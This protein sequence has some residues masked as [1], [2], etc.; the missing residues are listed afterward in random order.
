MSL[1]EV[2]ALLA[3]GR[4]FLLI[5][6]KEPDGDA[7]G[8]LLALGHS[9]RA[10]GKDVVLFTEEP[11]FPPFHLLRGARRIVHRLPG[12]MEFDAFVALDCAQ[13]ERLGGPGDV[14]GKCRALVNI[15]HHETNGL[16][17]D[18]H[19]VDPGCSSTGELVYRV[20]RA[21]GLP[22]GRDVAE[23]VF[24]AMQTDTG[25]F[26]Y[27]NTSP[28]CLRIAADLLDLGVSPWKV[29]RKILEGYGARRLELLRL[30]LGTLEFHARGRIGMMMLFSSMLRKT[31]ARRTDSE[32]FVDFP[33]AVKGVRIAVLIREMEEGAWKFSLRA[34]DETNVAR[35]AVRFHGGGHARAAGFEAQ[36]RLP[37]LRDRFLEEAER[38]LDAARH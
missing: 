13:Q 2:A 26:R 20:I 38:L 25:S 3:Q 8:S 15:D 19:Y 23:N 4:R 18:Y 10:A 11:V 6:H 29:T 22:V 12:N 17:G 36:G 1:A 28:S 35:L 7:L 30:C 9:L 33:R 16:F 21:A 14:V 32:R 34:N 37:A 31:G 24:A 5:T 27:E